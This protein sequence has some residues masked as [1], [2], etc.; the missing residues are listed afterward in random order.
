MFNTCFKE[1]Y[2]GLFMKIQGEH[3]SFPYGNF[4]TSTDKNFFN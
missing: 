2:K 1:N 4:K 3:K